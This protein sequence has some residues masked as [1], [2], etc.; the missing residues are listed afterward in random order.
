MKNLNIVL[1]LILCAM[2]LSG[3]TG[4]KTTVITTQQGTG[5]NT[6]SSSMVI[7][8]SDTSSKKKAQAD[9]ICDGINDSKILADAI[10]S[11][12]SGGEV[13]L[14]AG[15]YNLNQRLLVSGIPNLTLRGEGASTIL[16]E[17]DAINTTLSAPANAGQ[18]EIIVSSTKGLVPGQDIYFGST[19]GAKQTIASSGAPYWELQRMV[20]PSGESNIITEI[21]GKTLSLS[22]K[23][24]NSYNGTEDLWTMYDATYFVKC[25]NLK[26]LNLALDGNRS[27]QITTTGDIF[28]N[29]LR[30]TTCNDLEVAGV[31]VRNVYYNHIM[32]HPNQCLRANIHNNL[33]TTDGVSGDTQTRGI[34]IEAASDG[35]IVAEN[36][37]V[38]HETGIYDVG[39]TCSIE[40]NYCLNNQQYGIFNNR[41]TN[42]V[43]NGNTVRGAAVSGISIFNR[44]V[45]GGTYNIA[46]NNSISNNMIIAN[47]GGQSIDIVGGNYISI[48]NNH[49]VGSG[50]KGIRNLGGTHNYITGNYIIDAGQAE[51]ASSPGIELAVSP[52]M[53]PSR[54]NIVSDNIITKTL[55]NDLNYGILLDK[56]SSDNVIKNNYITGFAS[57]AINLSGSVNIVTGNT[58]W[59]AGYPDIR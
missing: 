17:N 55:A 43:I 56:P 29:G 30:F 27:N 20:G 59:I 45:G 54:F 46:L 51:N 18:S 52:D 49:I 7:A 15:T 9:I 58:Q 21:N 2:V 39:T 22:Y 35:T 40:N 16:R 50:K 6:G 8:A 44:D 32:L 14:L 28:L 13:F 24:T 33:V 48:T 12:T 38:G 47:R 19:T 1:I 5:I 11:L 37:I 26:V 25:N 23:L 53:E 10:A 42:V 41:G 34:V 36:Q 4:T 3:C 57:G 31:F